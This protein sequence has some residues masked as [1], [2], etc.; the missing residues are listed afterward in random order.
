[1]ESSPEESM[2]LPS[3]LPVSP[4]QGLYDLQGNAAQK[5]KKLGNV[6]RYAKIPSIS[7][8]LCTLQPCEG[9]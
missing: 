3:A 1:M 9:G 7:P 2:S 4:Q 5:G 6:P 8:T